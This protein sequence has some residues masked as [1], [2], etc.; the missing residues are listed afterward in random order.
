MLGKLF[1]DIF[2]LTEIKNLRSENEELKS[3]I[4][5]LQIE[6]DTAIS[7]VDRLCKRFDNALEAPIAIDFEGI[8]AVS[9]ERLQKD[10]NSEPITVIG[11][12]KNADKS[13]GEWYFHCTAERHAELIK[14][15]EEYVLSKKLVS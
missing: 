10:V 14:K 2:G 7:E 8:K 6:K 5:T 12:W 11:Y 4:R 3:T 13:L 15:F 1:S 9:V